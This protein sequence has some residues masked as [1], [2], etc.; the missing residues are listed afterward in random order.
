M[1]SKW[2]ITLKTSSIEFTL[3]SALYSLEHPYD[4]ACLRRGGEHQHS[5]RLH[6]KQKNVLLMGFKKLS[7]DLGKRSCAQFS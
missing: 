2:A 5:N 6:L 3:L 7:V 4:T 1:G